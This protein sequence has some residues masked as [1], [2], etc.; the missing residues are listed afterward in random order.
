M[1]RKAILVLL[2]ASVLL[3]AVGCNTVEGLGEDIST[4][5]RAMSEAAGSN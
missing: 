1:L 5:G 3:A 2:F 4:L